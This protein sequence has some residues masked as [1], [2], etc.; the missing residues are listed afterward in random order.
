MIWKD[1]YRCAV[2]ISVDFDAESLWSGTFKLNTPSPLSRG[3]YDIR[4]GIPRILALLERQQLPATF[5]VPGQVIDEHPQACRDIAKQRVE[6]GYHGYH[7]TS[8]LDVPIEEER[9]EMQ[10]GIA[11]IEEMFGTDAARQPLAAVRARPEHGRPAGGVRLR[12]RLEPVRPRRAVPAARPGARRPAAR[13]RR[14]AGELGARRRAV[15]PL[16][17]LPLH[18]GVATPSQVL[19]IWKAEFDGSYAA[20]G[21]FLLVVHPFCIGRYPRIAM[22]DEL[23]D[24]HQELRRR[25]VRAPTSRS[26]RSG[27][28]PRSGRARGTRPRSRR[29]R[30]RA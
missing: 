11:R 8:V 14:A 9:E 22:L 19:E 1:R 12:L 28:R 4:A 24:V 29:R 20:G 17:L 30:P 21:C 13:L 18:V 15:L 3:D 6:I 23:I 16:Q 2:T 10:R 27:A 26:P 7:H 5:M 25:V